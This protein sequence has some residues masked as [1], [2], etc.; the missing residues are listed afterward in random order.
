MKKQLLSLFLA[1]LMMFSMVACGTQNQGEDSAESG[2]RTITDMRGR[3][4][5]IPEKSIPLF[6]RAA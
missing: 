1:V 4:V 6:A 5:E 3:E 2:T